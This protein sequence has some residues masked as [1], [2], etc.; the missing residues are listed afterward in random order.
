MHSFDWNN[1]AIYCRRRPAAACSISIA[2]SFLFFVLCLRWTRSKKSPANH[3]PA[4]P[5]LPV[6]LPHRSLRALAE[7]HGPP[8]GSRPHRRRLLAGGRPRGL[9]DPRPRLREPPGLEPRRPTLLPHAEDCLQQVRRAVSPNAAHRRPPPP[10]PE[11]GV[12]LPQ[13]PRGRTGLQPSSQGSAQ[14]AAAR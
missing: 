1:P 7:K 4:A 9:E 8:L 13:G 5:G 2:S 6:S 14:P 10:Q 12:L 3:P 11:A